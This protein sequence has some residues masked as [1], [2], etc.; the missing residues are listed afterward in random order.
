MNTKIDFVITWVDGNDPEWKKNRAKYLGKSEVS[1]SR[2]REWD[3]LRYWFRSIE[4]N[5][6]WVNKIYFV[7]CGHIPSWLDTN[8][9]KLIIVRH[10]EFIEQRFLPTFNSCVIEA[11]LYK[12]KGLSNQFVYFNDD[13]FINN[14]VSPS[15]FFEKGLPCDN[16]KMALLWPK[17]KNSTYINYNCGKVIN[18]HFEI[19]NKK[20]YIR[21]TIKDVIKYMLR[22]PK[23]P[24]LTFVPEHVPT[25]FLKKTF[26]DVWSVENELLEKTC[27]NKFRTQNDVSQ[28]IF[29]FWQMASG[30]YSERTKKISQ[31]YE[32][33]SKSI[34]KTIEEI[35]N[36]KYK[37]ICIND[38]E[39]TDN[40]EENKEKI[41][42]MFEKM[43]P[44]KS[45]FEVK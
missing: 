9:K 10:D 21:I 29:Q 38:S 36:K 44:N 26:Y 35:R 32:I 2:Y 40:F 18:S 13:M 42:N 6:S 19:K 24:V 25:S 17:G 22:W 8:C 12:I 20:Q 28:W 37:L 33:N 43:Y 14:V 31:Y 11:N 1:E 27:F 4:K 15:D 41:I 23:K 45:K 5:A 30:E 39:D 7:T 3:I 34:N 16:K